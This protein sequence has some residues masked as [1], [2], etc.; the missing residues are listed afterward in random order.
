MTDT[1]A[2][3]IRAWDDQQAA[4]ITNREQRF[5]IML[6]V[7]ARACETSAAFGDDGAG[8]TVLDLACGP[9]SLSQRILDRFPAVRVVGID[10]DPVLLAV[11]STWLGKRHGSRFTPV[12]ADLAAPGWELLLPENRAHIAVSSTALHWLEPAQLVALYGTL[13]HVLEAG[14]VFMNADHL[15]YD[16][17]AQP[18]L[19]DLATD[20]DKRTQ[21][22]AHAQGVPTWEEWWTDAI[23]RPNLAAHNE[24]RTRRFAD[25]P[26]TPHAPLELH[27]SALRTAGF[28]E[29]GVLWRLYDDVVI[30]GR[31]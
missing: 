23:A 22:A 8:L 27:L 29:T 9:G 30:L 26:P 11:A 21:R 28:T 1:I 4:Y 13:G 20:D 31:R 15:R 18:M 25:R 2:D 16:P 10:Y 3:L 12:D 7:I 6:D 19:T 5:Q 14:G 17:A 24:E